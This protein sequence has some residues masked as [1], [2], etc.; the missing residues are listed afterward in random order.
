[1]NANVW[2]NLAYKDAKAAI[3]FLVEALGFEAAAVYER[4]PRAALPTPSCAGP[5]AA[6]S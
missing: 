4:D 5:A 3:Q 1:M 6:E 2:P